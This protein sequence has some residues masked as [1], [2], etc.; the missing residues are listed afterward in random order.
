MSLKIA[1]KDQYITLGQFLK[2]SNCISSGGEAKLFI[3]ERKIKV[4]GQSEQRRGRKIYPN[5]QVEVEGFGKF[6]VEQKI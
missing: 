5:D 3:L 1:I 2:L 4:N 6:E